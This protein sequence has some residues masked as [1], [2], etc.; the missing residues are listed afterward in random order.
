VAM[1]TA[2]TLAGWALGAAI[3]LSIPLTGPLRFFV[4]CA[5][6]LAVV[7][8]AASPLA[9]EKVRTRLETAIPR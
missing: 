9:L 3:R 6:W 8:T 7:M 1:M 2:V 4:E 5:V